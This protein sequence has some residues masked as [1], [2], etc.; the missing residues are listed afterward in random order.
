MREREREEFTWYEGHL[1]VGMV[2]HVCNPALGRLR[3]ENCQ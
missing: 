3:Q 2:V 1:D